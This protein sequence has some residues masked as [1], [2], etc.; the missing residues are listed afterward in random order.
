MQEGA[1]QED[2]G[3]NLGQL[4]G[5]WLSDRLWGQVKASLPI[6]C[7]DVIVSNTDGAVLLGWRVIRPYVNVWA[8]PG[9]RL[10]IGE[11]LRKAAQRVLFCHK[12]FARDF[13]LVG[14]FPVRFPSRF[15]VSMCVAASG[16]SGKPIP[17]GMEFTAVRWFKTP[18]TRT[19]KNY[20][21][22]IK[23]WHEIRRLPELI[24]FNQ[25]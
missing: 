5:G 21:E 22:M 19:G 11:D 7:V 25:L 23:K 6:A 2:C 4:E 13:Y 3:R 17:D 8:L 15:D 16:Y 9:G 20:R 1:S 24:K 14:V 18:P 12:I 10:R